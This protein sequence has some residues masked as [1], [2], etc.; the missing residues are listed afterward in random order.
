MNYYRLKLIAANT[1][2]CLER[3]L[4]NSRTGGFDVY[5]FNASL[6]PARNHY[7]IDILVSG[8]TSQNTLILAL[9]QESD[10]RSLT[11]CRQ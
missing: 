11:P 1:P 3:V 8:G 5:A 6:C 4:N 9:L 10:I 7:E 2:G